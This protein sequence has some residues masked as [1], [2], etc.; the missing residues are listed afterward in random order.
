MSLASPSIRKGPEDWEEEK[1][2]ERK[3]YQ[4]FPWRNTYLIRPP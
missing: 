1:T 3:G 4:P 2:M